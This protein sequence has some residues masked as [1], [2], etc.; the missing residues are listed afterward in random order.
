[1]HVTSLDDGPNAATTL[2][3]LRNAV[4][5]SGFPAGGRIVVFDV[6]GTINLTASLD[7]KNVNGLYIAGQTAPS[8]ITIVGETSQI[9][10]SNS[11]VTQNVILRYLTFR[12]GTGDG[13]DA[14]TFAGSGTG[15]NLILDH[16][17]ASWAEDETLGRQQQHERHRPVFDHR[18]EF[19]P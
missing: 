1:Y 12:K 16:V 19:E 11:K 17:S 18:R 15:T 5:E 14:I 2:G 7:I 3:T 8:P 10:S 9:T 6:G 13:S 4:R